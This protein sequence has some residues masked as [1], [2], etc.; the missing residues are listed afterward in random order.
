[1]GEGR[2]GRGGE[3]GVCVCVCEKVGVSERK[4]RERMF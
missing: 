1:M 4:E 3:R 2:E